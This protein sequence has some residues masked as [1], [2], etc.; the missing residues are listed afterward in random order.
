ME[1]SVIIPAYNE[2]QGLS[3]V[4]DE[5]ARLCP[6]EEII[7]V[8]DGSTDRTFEIASKFDKVKVIRHGKNYGYGAS[9]KSGINSASTQRIVFLDADGQHDVE[10]VVKFAGYLKDY[11]LVSGE[12]LNDRGI[13]GIRLP[14]KVILKTVVNFLADTKIKDIN[15]GFRAVRKNIIKRYL[16]LLPDGFSF[17]TTTILLLLKRK[18]KI[19][20]IPIQAKRRIG[21]SSVNQ[22][23]DGYN[24]LL[25]IIRLIGL[26]DPLRIFIPTG[27]FFI[28]LGVIY[29]L[30][31]IMTVGFGLSVGALAFLIIGF[32]G[33]LLGIICDQISS[34]RLEHLEESLKDS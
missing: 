8:D 22:L 5:L 4:L 18:H 16:F 1:F 17:S 33:F 9:L 10:Q 24:T 32:F 31:K 30:Y 7:V 27:F 14:G 12:R 3:K 21:R 13:S 26:F 28:M 15:C 29:G 34:L 19:K 25:L 11:D 23:R 20:F 2:E 6:G